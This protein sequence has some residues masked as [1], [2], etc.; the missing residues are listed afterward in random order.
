MDVNRLHDVIHGKV[1]GR[2]CGKTFAMCVEILQH[3]DFTREDIYIYGGTWDRVLWIK[4]FLTDIAFKM[5]YESV[6]NYRQD[7]LIVNG[8]RLI[9]GHRKPSHLYPPC[10]EYLDHDYENAIRSRHDG[11]E[12]PRYQGNCSRRV[13]SR[14]DAA[15][16]SL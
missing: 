11:Y 14:Q 10:I 13:T 7:I 6:E 3:T 9:F 12:L 16:R 15:Y 2:Q 5:G 1:G 8:T 4:S